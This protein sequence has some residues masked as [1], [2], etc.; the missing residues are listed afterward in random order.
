MDGVRVEI[1]INECRYP[2]VCEHCKEKIALHTPMVTGKSWH[3]I[4]KDSS[5]PQHIYHI[6]HWHVSRPT[7]SI[8]CWIEQG[9]TAYNLKLLT[10]EE[11][12]G[13]KTLLIDS[14]TRKKR[15]QILQRHAR[16]VQMLRE[17]MEKLASDAIISVHQ[18]SWERV[19]TLGQ[20][21]EELK[22]QILPLGGVPKSWTQEESVSLK[23]TES[24][25]LGLGIGASCLP[26]SPTG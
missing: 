13:G 1:Y 15:L 8:C 26:P 9:L 11:K 7:D 2:V 18:G 23:K 3:I 22:E 5:S 6:L 14:E 24:S 17:E 19:A 10:K 21:L 4:N 16:L 12:R 25:Y 20:R